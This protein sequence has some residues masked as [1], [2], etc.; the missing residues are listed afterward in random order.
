MI[1][2]DDISSNTANFTGAIEAEVSYGDRED[3][4]RSIDE[5]ED[6]DK[7]NDVAALIVGTAC[8]VVDIKE[9]NVDD[10]VTAL[11]ERTAGIVVDTKE[12]NVVDDAAALIEGSVGTVDDT[13]ESNVVDDAA[14][15]IE[16]SVGI[17]IDTKESNVVDDAAALIEGS[18]GTVDDTKDSNVVDNVAKRIMKNSNFALGYLS[19]SNLKA[20]IKMKMNVLLSERFLL[21]FKNRNNFQ[22]L[23]TK[24]QDIR[25]ILLEDMK[26]I[27]R[28]SFLYS[29]AMLESNSYLLGIDSNCS[30]DIFRNSVDQLLL[31]E[32]RLNHLSD[33]EMKQY[34]QITYSQT[35]VINKFIQFCVATVFHNFY[36]LKETI[37]KNDQ[38]GNLLISNKHFMDIL[39]SS[40]PRNIIT[41]LQNYYPQ[42]KIRSTRSDISYVG[43]STS[44]KRP[45][46]RNLE[47]ARVGIHDEDGYTS[48]AKITAKK[49]KLDNEVTP[50][51]NDDVV[52]EDNSTSTSWKSEQNHQPIDMTPV[53]IDITSKKSEQKLDNEV[54][55]IDNDDVVF[56]DASS[57]T[58][59]K[60]EQ[61]LDNEVTPMH[62]DDVVFEDNSS[63]TLWKS[64][65]NHQPIDMT[66]VNIGM[67]SKKSEQ[68]LDNEVSPID[69][70]DVVFVDA[71]S[72]TSWKSEQKLD[73]EVT[74]MDDDADVVFLGNEV[75]TFSTDDPILKWFTSLQNIFVEE[76]GIILN[77]QWVD[78]S[79]RQHIPA[80]EIARLNHVR[81]DFLSLI[82]T[83]EYRMSADTP[84]YR[85]S[86]DIKNFLQSRAYLQIQLKYDN[87]FYRCTKPDGLCLLRSLWQQKCGSSIDMRKSS[88]EFDVWNNLDVDLSK[89]ENREEFIEFLYSLIE[90]LKSI[91][92]DI[93]FWIE[94]IQC[95]LNKIKTF[96]GDW[97]EF[98]LESNY[99]CGNLVLK[100]IHHMHIL[101]SLSPLE[102]LTSHRILKSS[103]ND[104]EKVLSG[105]S[106][107]VLCVLC[108]GNPLMCI[109]LVPHL[110][111]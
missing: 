11:I 66:P 50:M 32:F 51:H 21:E 82:N 59:W 83:P 43:T 22:D 61:K 52:F 87:S 102:E 34:R 9:S 45:V 67:T 48:N 97:S 78:T 68:K 38:I 58:S 1:E 25:H 100:C 99:W 49:A 101:N 46:K 80:I 4:G 10:D 75:W 8:T 35:K 54:T 3:D 110:C 29:V 86:A 104:F 63:S 94:K 26:H 64:E 105:I 41:L 92:L 111:D 42:S 37:Q 16:G 55:A 53:D 90:A 69:N 5:I 30:F 91:S 23:Y 36:N 18:V 40:D 12:S 60:S 14:A 13:K 39:R 103:C 77:L 73:N 108:K 6:A 81:S 2:S 28:L 47:S 96:K 107:L 72:S 24:F 65:Q 70:D 95:A 62:N 7:V 76:S 106:T 93:N 98:K 15:L 20:E 19:L 71:S 31:N 27:M 74:Q 88:R 17:V 84:D 109:I 85:M 33:A 89:T 44:A 56:V 79:G 57:L